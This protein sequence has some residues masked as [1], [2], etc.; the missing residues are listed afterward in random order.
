MT[1]GGVQFGLD[2]GITNAKGMVSE[3][4]SIAI[5]RH[6]IT[7][8]IQ[9]I[10]T[11]SAYGDSER[12]IGKSLAGGWSNRVK[13]ITKLPPFSEE[14]LSENQHL[15]LS[16]MVR[17]L[18]LQSCINLK[19]DH[20]DSFMLHRADHLKHDQILD[21]LKK[22]RKEGR[23]NH[24]SVSVQSPQELEVVLKNKEVSMIQMPYN[25]LDYRWDTMIDV[26]KHEREQR[27][28]IVHARSALLQGLLCSED[29]SKWLIAGIE[30]SPVIVSWLKTKFKQHEK[31]SVSDLCI[32]YANSQDWIDSVVIGVDSEKSLFSNLQSISM[33]L[34]SKATLDDLS[35]SRIVVDSKSL[36]P[37]N[38]Q[39]N[40]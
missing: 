40:V 37:T 6:A 13:V 17:N 27:S 23:I 2:Y 8:G 22:L 31:I 38:W 7:E 36:D 20:I 19:V 12:V 28:L 34:M 32:G 39:I 4:D 14:V 30:N 1:L 35:A 26:I 5:I 15:S 21:E 33:P 16:I 9:Y 29:V 25:I 24:I 10:D 3:R 18:F 11:A